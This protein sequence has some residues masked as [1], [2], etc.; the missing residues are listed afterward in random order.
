MQATKKL[1]CKLWG[2]WAASNQDARLQAT[3]MLGCK[4]WGCQAAML[5]QRH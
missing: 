5:I 3:G 4:L 2:C 1:S